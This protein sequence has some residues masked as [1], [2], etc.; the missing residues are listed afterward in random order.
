MCVTLD[1]KLE[2]NIQIQIEVNKSGWSIGIIYNLKNFVPFNILRNMNYTLTY[3]Y[4]FYCNTVWSN[5]HENCL[6]PLFLLQKSILRLIC[7]KT[8]LAHTNFLFKECKIL[9][10]SEINTLCVS[11]YKHKNKNKFELIETHDY[12]TRN[13]R[14]LRNTRERINIS[15]Q[16]ISHFWPKKTIMSRPLT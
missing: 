14:N 16:N 15:Q 13:R 1:D 2:F 9:K 4:I 11:V 8:F 12:I 10:L 6:K 5:T 7:N 3:P